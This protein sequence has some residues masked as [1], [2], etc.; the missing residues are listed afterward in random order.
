M[1]NPP[2]ISQF[3]ILSAQSKKEING[4][5]FVGVLMDLNSYIFPF[6]LVK[7]VEVG[8]FIVLCFA[9]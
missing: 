9:A 6:K 7:I 3:L 2:A 8:T 4:G 1:I 5:H